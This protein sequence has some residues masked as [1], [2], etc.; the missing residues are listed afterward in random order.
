[1]LTALVSG[2]VGREIAPVWV[3]R[4][5]VRAE[6]KALP[7]FSAASRCN[8]SGGPEDSKALACDVQVP[9]LHPTDQH[10]LIHPKGRS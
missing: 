6:L 7:G 8:R 2:V 5:R 3:F 9:R 4:E 1:M 10:P